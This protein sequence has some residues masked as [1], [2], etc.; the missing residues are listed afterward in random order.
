MNSIRPPDL[1]SLRFNGE[2]WKRKPT[3]GGS[4]RLRQ[5]TRGETVSTALGGQEVVG[6]RMVSSCCDVKQGS[7]AE[8]SDGVHGLVPEEPSPEGDRVPVRAKKRGNARGAKGGRAKESAQ[9][10]G[11]QRKLVRVPIGLNGSGPKTACRVTMCALPSNGS[12]WPERRGG[13]TAI[14]SS[15]LDGPLEDRKI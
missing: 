10:V 9:S 11:G 15:S 8:G 13:I 6:D 14:I 5:P 2:V 4:G 7:R 1:T 12:Q 3:R